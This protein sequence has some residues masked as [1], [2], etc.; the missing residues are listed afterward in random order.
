MIA[1]LLAACA[2]GV[3]YLATAP[4]ARRRSRRLRAKARWQTRHYGERGCTVV[5]VSLT[6][7]TGEV[8]DE[9]VVARAPDNDPD[10]NA[11]FLA[12]KA[13]AEERAFHLNA[14]EP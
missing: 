9:H 1:L 11:R 10:W 14:G 4:L 3:T 6:L 2:A 12:A 7:P 13:E 8:F 5:A